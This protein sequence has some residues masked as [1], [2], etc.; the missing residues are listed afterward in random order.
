MAAVAAFLVAT[1]VVLEMV[2]VTLG[3]AAAGGPARFAELVGVWTADPQ[4]A[5][6]NVTP[7]SWAG[8]A[9]VATVFGTFSQAL[10]WGAWAEIYRG[11][12]GQ[13][14]EPTSVW[15]PV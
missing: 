6:E 9:V 13:T 12:S 15:R 14:P 5:L 11:L 8:L 7:I 1:L 2:I 4:A 3:V 10:L